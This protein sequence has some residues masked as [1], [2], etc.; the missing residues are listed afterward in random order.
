MKPWL[1]NGLLLAMVSSGLFIVKAQANAKTELN[2]TIDGLKSLKGQVCISVFSS[3]KGFPSSKN[4]AVQ[5]RCLGVTGASETISF[6]NLDPGSYA[7]AVIHDAN[8]D[9]KLNRNLLGIPIEGFGFS[10]NP[11]ILT[12]P[13]KFGES[14]IIVSGQQT[15]IRIQL[16]YF[17]V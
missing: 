2:I 13:P 17:G 16:K 1:I 5:A 11:K 12:G 7:V 4:Q 10:N 9:G 6:E 8:I 3:S 15:N 14:A